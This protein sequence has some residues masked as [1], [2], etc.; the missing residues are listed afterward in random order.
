MKKLTVVLG[1]AV[2]MILGL[3]LRVDAQVSV[4]INIGSQPNW[5]P[6]GYQHVDYYYLPDIES[7]YY[8]PSRQF[9]Y[10]S[11]GNWVFSASLPSR[12]RNYD[13]YR[14][15][16]VVVNQPRPYLHYKEHK[17]KYKKYK[18]Y[19]DKPYN[20][21]GNDDREGNY[22]NKSYNSYRQ[23]DYHEDKGKQ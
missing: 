21:R 3:N 4:N 20:N 13:L 15:Y 22:S 10:L 2:I 8:V 9:I 5:G 16:K 1:I 11:N 23:A 6:R 12:Y 17:I 18:G 7:Y 19:N 14:G